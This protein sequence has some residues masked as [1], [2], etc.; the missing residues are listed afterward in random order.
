MLTRSD[1]IGINMILCFHYFQGDS[2]KR[3]KHIIANDI[4]VFFQFVKE[5]SGSKKISVINPVSF[6]IDDIYK[7][8]V[9]FTL[10]DGL[11]TQYHA[12][13][14]LESYDIKAIFFISSCILD[15][16]P[17][18]PMIIHHGISECG[19]SNFL[20]LF[21]EAIKNRVSQPYKYM[22]N[23]NENHSPDTI[24]N[25]I[26]SIVKYHLPH[27]I[28]TEVLMD[29][30][31]EHLLPDYNCEM[32]DIHLTKNQIQSILEM[33]HVLGCHTHNHI[34]IN[35]NVCSKQD[36]I[37]TQIIKSKQMISNEF[38]CNVDYFAY[39]FGSRIDTLSK[40]Q[41]NVITNNFLK[42]FTTY[43]FN[44][45][46]DNYNIGRYCVESNASVVELINLISR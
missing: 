42:A 45:K 33:G 19:I 18:N 6:N 26:K 23:W 1:R 30:Y 32:S 14:I 24:I 34:V 5:I 44:K 7:P 29:V 40:Y 10:D 28:S 27:E 2:P 38:N 35:D 9:L 22:V 12:A 31:R 20:N 36:V 11:S 25:N 43:D 41:N 4:N 15:N 37:E 8:S 17:A 39:P 46:T 3:F 16:M 21:N 13:E